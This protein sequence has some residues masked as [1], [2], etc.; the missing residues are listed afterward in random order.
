MLNEFTSSFTEDAGDEWNGNVLTVPSATSTLTNL[1]NHGG[2]IL[3]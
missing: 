3:I 1:K 2:S